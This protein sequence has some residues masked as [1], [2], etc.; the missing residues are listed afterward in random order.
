ML[1]SQMI[2]KNRTFARFAS[3]QNITDGELC[4]AIGQ[5]ESGLVDANLGGG[6]LKQRIA[7]PNEGKS[8]G[9]R[10]IIVF[11]AGDRSFFVFGFAKNQRGNIRPDELKAFK[12]L[13]ADLL[14]YD[15]EQLKK[16]VEAGALIE[17]V[18]NQREANEQNEQ[19][20][21]E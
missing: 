20:F 2:F 3:H 7:R 1:S 18:C 6:V 8:G 15:G 21:Q 5:A 17:V 19:D 12:E 9:F 13:A 11:R 14:A 10:S 16:A 4:D